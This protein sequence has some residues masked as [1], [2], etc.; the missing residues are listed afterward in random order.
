MTGVAREATEKANLIKQQLEWVAKARFAIPWLLGGLAVLAIVANEASFQRSWRSVSHSIALTDAR[1][2]AA[3]T[4]QAITVMEAAARAALAQEHA[5]DRQRFEAASGHYR[6]ARVRT[7]DLI[8]KVDTDGVVSLDRLRIL[9]DEQAVRYG[10]WM[11]QAGLEPDLA[12]RSSALTTRAGVAELQAEFDA[13]LSKTAAVQQVARVSI[14]SALQFN[15]IAVH[16]LV[17]L[18]VLGLALFAQQLRL[19]DAARAREHERLALQVKERTAHLHDLADHLTIVREDERGRLARDLHD[20]MGGL[21]T[22]MKLELAR[23]RRMPDVPAAALER[24]VN[25]DTRLNEGIAFKRRIIENLRPSSLDQL[26]LRVALEMLCAD[27]SKVMAV[28]VK[29]N[30]Q[31][32]SLNGDRQLTIYRIVQESLTNIAKYASA[33]T[34]WVDLSQSNAG[35]GVQDPGT[36]TLAVR[37]D[38]SGFD[39]AN[40]SSGRH[41]LLGMQ[42]RVEG[43]QGSLR[44][45]SNVG[46]GTQIVASFP[47]GPNALQQLQS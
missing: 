42:V 45:T 9:S 23:L 30:I 33:C 8:A 15:R 1:V 16:A 28:P 14:F 5:S 44:V 39:T 46:Q 32:V 12:T 17:L 36:V 26:G 13:V 40:V 11:A 22:A 27:L 3:K 6:A 18:S 25:V 2:Q 4:L 38:G 24:L 34:V 10:E 31:D 41:G 47:P 35:S 37:D 21:M 20:E 19:A 43:Q 7:L 29:V